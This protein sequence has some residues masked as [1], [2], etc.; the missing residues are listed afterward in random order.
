[1]E[2]F[3]DFASISRKD[4]IFKLIAI[5]PEYQSDPM[6]SRSS[7][8]KDTVFGGMVAHICNPNTCKAESGR[9]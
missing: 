7:V 3:P 4:T 5:Q 8:R 6:S 1:V 9:S 2:L